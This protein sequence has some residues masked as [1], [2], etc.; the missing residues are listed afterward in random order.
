MIFFFSLFL[1]I[2]IVLALIL[3]PTMLRSE[4]HERGKDQ[5]FF[6]WSY[7]LAWGATIFLIAACGLLVFDRNKEEIFYKEK[8]YLNQEDEETGMI[9]QEAKIKTLN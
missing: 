7:G 5:W 2:S 1:V 3:F 9:D 6:G 4:L 8:L